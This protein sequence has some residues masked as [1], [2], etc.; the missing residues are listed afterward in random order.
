MGN[1]KYDREPAMNQW[2][3]KAKRRGIK[4]LKQLSDIMFVTEASQRNDIVE[5]A[6][7]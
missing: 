2:S 4:I 5:K 7:D 6:S 3:N 1:P